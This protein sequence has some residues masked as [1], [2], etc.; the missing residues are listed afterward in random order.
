MT[1]LEIVCPF[2]LLIWAAILVVLAVRRRNRI[3]RREKERVDAM[4]RDLEKVITDYLE[5]KK[6]NNSE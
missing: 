5:K 6:S 1:G 3:K 2:A 4:I